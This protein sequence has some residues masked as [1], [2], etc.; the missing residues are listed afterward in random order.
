MAVDWQEVRREFP[1][2]ENWTYLNTATFG[3]LPRRAS[4]A[5]ARHLGHRDELACGDFLDWYNDADR[6]RGS[7]AELICCDP[8]D[9]AFVTNAASALATLI[10]G[11]EWNPGDRVVTL[12]DEFPNNLYSPALLGRA[13]VE[14][15][16][17]PWEGFRDAITP[18]TR[19]VILS[20]VNYTNGF[21]PPLD[22]IAEFLR[23]RGVLLYVDGTQ[24]VGALRFDASIIQPAM[25]AVH[26]YKWLLGPTGSGFIHV[27]PE[28]RGKLPPTVIGWR[29]HRDWRRVDSLH[30]GVPEFVEAAEKYE[31]GMLSFLPLLA[32]GASVEF[33]L[34][35]GPERI[36]R[37]V[38]DLA[39]KLRALLRELGAR[40]VFDEKP[41]Y[42]SPVIAARFEGVD[43]S[44]LAVELK[45]RRVLVSARHGNLRVSTHFYNN[46]DDLAR[47][48]DELL[49]LL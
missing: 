19:L 30:H 21:R 48:R 22:E 45:K 9:V 11:L 31:G 27:H 2:L 46:E 29:S 14:P 7:V 28:L 33:M 36:E 6:I 41:H 35:I 13:G 34:E 10:G 37:R 16:E 3:Q 15:V 20:T 5:V 1:A 49:Q 18:K 44:R 26:A 23:A 39:D 42:D 4:D 8:T 38:M 25:M 40:L 43:A 47:L 17:V 32:M 24:S 12:C